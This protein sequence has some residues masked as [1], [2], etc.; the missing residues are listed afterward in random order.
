MSE[1]GANGR[2]YPYVIT[3]AT[4]HSKQFCN[5]K[6]NEYK[7]LNLTLNFK[8]ATWITLT[9]ICMLHLIVTLVAS[10]ALTVLKG[11]RWIADA[12][13][14]IINLS[15]PMYIFCNHLVQIML[16]CL[17]YSRM[18]E[19]ENVTGVASHGR[20][21]QSTRVGAL[22]ASIVQYCDKWCCTLIQVGDTR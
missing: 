11:G 7:M 10:E 6:V 4:R 1:A 12:W 16:P 5:E 13:F 3:R 20:K 8:S 18:S 15:N 21:L 14:E 17:C 9:S 22:K 19:T 2:R